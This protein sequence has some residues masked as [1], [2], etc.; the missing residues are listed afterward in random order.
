MIKFAFCHNVFNHLIVILSFIESVHILTL[1][2]NRNMIKKTRWLELK[3]KWR[4][5][6]L[7]VVSC[8]HVVFNNSSVILRWHITYSWSLGKRTGTRL[9]NMPSAEGHSTMTTE[10]WLVMEPRRPVQKYHGEIPFK[11]I[12]KFK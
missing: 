6:S 10:P 12:R 7:V 5:E 1:N 2:E 9:G 4:R 3:N 11:I 8:F